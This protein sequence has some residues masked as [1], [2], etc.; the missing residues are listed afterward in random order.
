MSIEFIKDDF[1][2]GKKE[3]LEN[4]DRILSEKP[5][6]IDRRTI[7]LKRFTLALMGQYKF[8]NRYMIKKHEE[9]QMMNKQ[10]LQRPI[11]R[12][13][14]QATLSIPTPYGLQVPMPS[15]QRV[16]MNIS[17]LRIPEPLKE[18]LKIPNPI[19][20]NVPRPENI[21]KKEVTTPKPI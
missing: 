5:K 2:E 1:L 8:Q 14:S 21:Q 18:E 13:M 7:F 10:I 12:I 4:I 9:M 19:N 15:V 16:S 17:Q 3:E 6:K 11:Q 20:I